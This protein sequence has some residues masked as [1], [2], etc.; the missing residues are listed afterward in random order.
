M[1]NNGL[2]E[3]LPSASST[4]PKGVSRSIVNVFLS[5]GTILFSDAVISRPTWSRPPQR[6][7]DATQSSAVTGVPS[8]NFSPSRSVNEYFIAS[9]DTVYLSTICGLIFRSASSARSVSKIM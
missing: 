8:W 7:I 2:A 9:F 5:T 4:R 3:G 1:M 6:L